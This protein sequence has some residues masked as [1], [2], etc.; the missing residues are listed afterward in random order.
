[1]SRAWSGSADVRSRVVPAY[2]R[3]RHNG[4]GD[5]SCA[6]NSIVETKGSRG[7]NYAVQ[8]LCTSASLPGK[9]IVRTLGPDRAAMRNRLSARVV[10]RRCVLR[11]WRVGAIS[12]E[13]N[14]KLRAILNVIEPHDP[15]PIR[16]LFCR[17]HGD[18]RRCARAGYGRSKRRSGQS[19]S[20]Q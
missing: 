14:W 15:S 5:G 1:M 8:A 9:T 4:D 16:A 20:V 7:I 19:T 3:N 10:T 17:L 13:L 6:V 18:Q 11:R 12:T 2:P